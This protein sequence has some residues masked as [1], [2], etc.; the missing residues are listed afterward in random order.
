MN[1]T[2]LIAAIAEKTNLTKKDS[3]LAL[4]AALEAITEA[5][6]EGD[7]VQL[8]GFGSFEIKNR[9]AREAR[10]PRTGETI[11]V[12]ASKAPVFKAGKALKD[13]VAQ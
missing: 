7:K 5:L 12:A 3:E 13:K 4:A 2:E 10:N 1:K 6:V 8:I 9:E 11:K